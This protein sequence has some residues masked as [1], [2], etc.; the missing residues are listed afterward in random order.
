MTPPEKNDILLFYLYKRTR[1]GSLKEGRDKSLFVLVSM[2][3]N[4]QIAPFACWSITSATGDLTADEHL[5]HSLGALLN[6]PDIRDEIHRV[7]WTMSRSA[8][9]RILPSD[10]G[11]GRQFKVVKWVVISAKDANNVSTLRCKTAK[12]TAHPPFC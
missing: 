11:V 6:K 12:C 1:G 10:D 3:S 2:F 5:L 4:Q 9:V 7:L 8:G